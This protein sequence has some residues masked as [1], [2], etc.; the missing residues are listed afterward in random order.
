MEVDVHV[1]VRNRSCGDSVALGNVHML[2]FPLTT[3]DF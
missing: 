2:F 1:S 3:L